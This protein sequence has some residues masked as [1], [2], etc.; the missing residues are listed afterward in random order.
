[1]NCRR[2]GRL[3]VIP[4]HES[5]SVLPAEAN[6]KDVN[7]FVLLGHDFGANSWQRKHSL[8]L[9]PGLND[10][11]AYGYY[12]AAGEGW[13]IKYSHDTDESSFARICRLALRKFLG[14]DFIHVCRN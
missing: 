14:F 5:E 8:G 2:T 1:M 7:V 3:T 9:I 11:L 4:F 10:R 13:S 6:T 12:R